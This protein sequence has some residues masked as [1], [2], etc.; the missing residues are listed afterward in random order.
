MGARVELECLK[1]GFYPKG[2]GCVEARVTPLERPLEPLRWTTR[3]DLRSLTAYSVVSA[4]LPDH[5]IARQV[6]GAREALGDA[7]IAVETRHPHAASPGTMLMVAAGFERGRGGFAALGERGKPAEQVGREAGREA[8]SFLDGNASV[9]MH[10][11]DQLLIYGAMAGEET[12]YRTENVTAHLSTNRWTIQQFLQVEIDIDSS[13][14]S[15][16]I[17]G[18]GLRPAARRRNEMG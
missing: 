4:D 15:V 7:G 8:A 2:G 16:T 17:E 6:E 12:R 1:P 11:A 13:T 14:G 3:G 5:I 18:A 10:L 9:D